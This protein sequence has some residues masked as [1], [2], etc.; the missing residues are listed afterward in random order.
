MRQ[1]KKWK[2][3]ENETKNGIAKHRKRGKVAHTY[4]TWVMW[5]KWKLYSPRDGLML[6]ANF[7][8]KGLELTLICLLHIHFWLW[9]IIRHTI[10]RIFYRVNLILPWLGEF[11]KC[12]RWNAWKNRRLVW[13]AVLIIAVAKRW[14]FNSTVYP[15][16]ILK[17]TD[18]E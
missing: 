6:L 8:W 12:L 11:S 13:I 16:I 14:I 17:M 5:S 15:S 7:V 9:R 3:L 2:Q 10:V 1:L 18:K 4:V